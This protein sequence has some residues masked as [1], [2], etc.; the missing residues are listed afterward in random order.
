M[1]KGSRREEVNVRDDEVISTQWCH[2]EPSNCGGPQ[3][4]IRFCGTRDIILN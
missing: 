1:V 2:R 3:E 4:L